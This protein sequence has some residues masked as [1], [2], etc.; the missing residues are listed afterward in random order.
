M[1]GIDTAYW[2]AAAEL[3][4]SDPAI[5]LA[6]EPEKNEKKEMLFGVHKLFFAVAPAKQIS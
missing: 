2:R 1:R 5:L 6:I 4:G 3:P